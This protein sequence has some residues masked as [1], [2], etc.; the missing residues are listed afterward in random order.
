VNEAASPRAS[1]RTVAG[2]VAQAG[3]WNFGGQITILLATVSAT[4]FTIRLLGPSRYGLWSLLQTTLIWV[5]LA[6]LGMATASTK[7]A[8]ERYSHNDQRSEVAVIWTALFITVSATICA[9]TVVGMFAPFI[10]SH[11]FHVP[12]NLLTSGVLALRIICP[13]FLFQAITGIVNTPQIVRLKW[14]LYTVIMSGAT[15]AGIVGVPIALTLVSRQIAIVA[16]VTLGGGALAA[17]GN[18]LLAVRL[19][20]DLTHPRLDFHIARRLLGFGGALS[21][22]GLAAIPLSSG[23]RFLLA[24]NSSTVVVA[25]YAVA[26]SLGMILSVIPQALVAPMLPGLVRLRSGGHTQEYRELYQRGLQGLFLVLA[27]AAAVI[28]FLAHPF[29][30]LWAGPAYG[31]YS[32]GPFYIIL[33]GVFCNSLAYMP[34]FH[35]LASGKAAT[36]A[37]IHVAEL[38]PYIGLAVVLTAHF[39]ALGAATVWSARVVADA[40]IYFIAARQTA[41]VSFSPLSARRTASLL[42][43]LLLVGAMLAVGPSVGGLESRAGLSLGMSALYGIA[44]WKVVLTHPERTGLVTLVAEVI[45]SFSNRLHRPPRRLHSRPA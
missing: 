4:P 39:G 31:R 23:E 15:V 9:S 35:L 22:S 17:V 41:G 3:V 10:V 16:V 6:D 40:V 44:V 12:K 33:A 1:K 32:I 14:R 28:A 37:R 5:A 26:A 29:L 25:Y 24:H 21:V 45:P 2:R 13:L 43:P 36:V 11:L 30:T 7:L 19:Q 20:P 34:Y 8:T 42:S 27:P 38:A 18:V